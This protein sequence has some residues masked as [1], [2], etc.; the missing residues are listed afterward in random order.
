[1]RSRDGF[2]VLRV[3][4]FWTLCMQWRQLQKEDV[5]EWK[6]LRPRTC[7]SVPGMA[8]HRDAFLGNISLLLKNRFMKQGGVRP[9][10]CLTRPLDTLTTYSHRHTWIKIK[11]IHFKNV[12]FHGSFASELTVA[13]NIFNIFC[14]QSEWGKGR[15]SSLW[16]LCGV[17]SGILQRPWSSLFLSVVSL[18]KALVSQKSAL[19]RKHCMGNSRNDSQG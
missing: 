1:M 17:S 6:A 13:V 14:S 18:P 16:V 9:K 12:K 10:D 2:H 19:V 8:S 15:C 7:A 3:S 4:K 11:G 5:G